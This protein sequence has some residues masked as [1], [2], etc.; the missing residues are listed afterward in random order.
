MQTMDFWRLCERLTFVQAALLLAGHDP[1]HLAIG[2]EYKASEKQPEGYPACRAAI[3]TA[4]LQDKVIG[5]LEYN[6]PGMNEGEAYLC[7]HSSWVEVESL[8]KWLLEK[9]FSQHFFFF[10]EGVESE[11]LDINHP[12]YAPKLAA[13]VLAWRALDT[14]E[15]LKAKS[16]KQ[17][18]RR[19][20]NLN[21]AQFDLCDSEGKPT[22]SAIEEI[23]KVANWLTKGGAPSTPDDSTITKELTKPDILFLSKPHTP[24]EPERSSYELDDDIPF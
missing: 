13:A 24:P 5:S 12:R 6:E 7:N 8:K 21:A 18:L 3:E 10:P 20:L 2:I 1:S 19:W 23:A 15:S 17:A 9:G 11:F 14:P 16:P 22:E 4:V